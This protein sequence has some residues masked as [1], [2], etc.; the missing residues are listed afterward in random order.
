M[1]IEEEIFKR[2]KVVLKKLIKYGF[3]KKKMDTNIQKYL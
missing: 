2:K 1:N 3:I